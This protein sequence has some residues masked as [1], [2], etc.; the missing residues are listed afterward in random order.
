ML[1]ENPQAHSINV[2]GHAEND[3]RPWS[4]QEDGIEGG[5]PG[6]PRGESDVINSG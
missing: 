4:I 2:Y 1:G 3:A 5:V 6:K